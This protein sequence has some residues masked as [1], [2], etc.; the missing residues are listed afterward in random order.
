MCYSKPGPRCASHL[1]KEIAEAESLI[2]RYN[3]AHSN[4]STYENV[5]Y[6]EYASARNKV[7]DLRFQL[8]GTPSGQKELKDRI[9]NESNPN[10]VQALQDLMT[11]SGED[12][13][14]KL[15][16]Y[17]AHQAQL[18]IERDAAKRRQRAMNIL[19]Q[20]SKRNIKNEER[21]V[22]KVKKPK[23]PATKSTTSSTSHV[24]SSGK[25]YGSG[26]W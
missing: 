11:L 1:R 5:D 26:K 21:K 9:A 19:A 15:K 6:Q 2:A 3:K 8:A 14:N 20:D 25:G 18:K 13:T 4:P 24:Y 16:D 23:A 22:P 10:T 7:E 17:R 12:Y